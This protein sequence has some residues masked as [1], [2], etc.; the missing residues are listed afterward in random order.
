MNSDLDPIGLEATGEG[1][2]SF[3][4]QIDIKN[5]VANG[6]VKMA[7]LGHIRAEAGGAPFEAY[8]THDP[9]FHQ[10]VQAIVDCGHRNIRQ[11]LLGSQEYLLGGGM[12]PPLQQDLVNALSLRCETQA[13][14]RE[15]LIDRSVEFCCIHSHRR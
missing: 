3:R 15:P 6:A 8:L 11:C 13:A 2:A 10:S 7:M 4:G 5:V 9:A 12:V 14:F 1:H